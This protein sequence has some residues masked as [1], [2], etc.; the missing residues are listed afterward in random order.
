MA[1]KPAHRYN[2]YLK[3]AIVS[4]LLLYFFFNDLPWGVY[5]F[6]TTMFLILSIL[7]AKH[8]KREGRSGTTAFIFIIISVIYVMMSGYETVIHF[9]TIHNHIDY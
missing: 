1:T 8:D 3:Y 7:K 6:F 5:L 9:I 4:L 2:E